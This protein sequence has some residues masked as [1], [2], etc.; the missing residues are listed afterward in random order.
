MYMYAKTFLIKFVMVTLVVWLVL[1]MYYEVSV[2]NVLLTSIALTVLGYIGDIFLM[3]RIGNVFAT[4]GDFILGFLV[5]YGMGA[6]LYPD[7]PLGTAA[8]VISLIL[9][10]GEM[11]LHQYIQMHVFEPMV[12]NPLDKKG[13]YQRVP[14]Y[15]N[16]AEFKQIKNK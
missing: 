10:I 4:F 11:W 2:M 8:F 5:V 13:Y 9:S 15:D 7:I 1:G 6:L 14:L 16:Y 12:M 3:P